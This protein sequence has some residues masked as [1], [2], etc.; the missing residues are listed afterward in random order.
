MDTGTGDAE[1]QIRGLPGMVK[2]VVEERGGASPW[3]QQC[4]H[5]PSKNQFLPVFRAGPLPSDPS[6]FLAV[7]A[8]AARSP[9]ALGSHKHLMGRDVLLTAASRSQQVGR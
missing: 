2:K 6:D 8:P 1:G 4:L 9:G 5:N 7:P 3:H